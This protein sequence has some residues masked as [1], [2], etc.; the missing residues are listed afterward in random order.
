M[1]NTEKLPLFGNNGKTYFFKVYPLKGEYPAKAGVYLFTKRVPAPNA[2]FTIVSIGHT[3][4]FSSIHNLYLHE[5]NESDSI[6]TVCLLPMDN[7]DDRLATVAELAE[8]YG[9]ICNKGA[10]G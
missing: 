10:N 8:R 7:A 3:D 6:N 2:I 5:S 4:H 9:L 1:K